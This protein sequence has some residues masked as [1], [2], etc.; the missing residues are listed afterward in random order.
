M[1]N[2]VARVITYTIV[3][4]ASEGRVYLLNVYDKSDFSSV[5]VSIIKSIIDD[6]ESV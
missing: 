6:L 4:N 2:P 3:I 5:D 1:A